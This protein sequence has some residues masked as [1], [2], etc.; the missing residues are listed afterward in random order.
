MTGAAHAA[1][2]PVGPVYNAKGRIIETPLAPPEQPRRL[3]PGKAVDIFLVYPKVK[4]WLSRYPK[5][6]RTTAADWKDDSGSW[7]AHA[8]WGKAGEVPAGRV[9]DP[10]ADPTAA[11]SGPG[12]GRGAAA[13]GPAALGG[14]RAKRAPA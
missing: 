5:K 11:G 13:G 10:P 9:G 2:E 6:G 1:D 8:W 4:D 14:P 12:V 3:T 7:Q